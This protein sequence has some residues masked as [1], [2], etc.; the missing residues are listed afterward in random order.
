M[1]L[2]DPELVRRQYASEAGLKVRRESQRRFRTGP[3]AF[4]VAFDVISKL[5]RA[6]CSRSV[7]GWAT[8]PSGSR[9]RR[10]PR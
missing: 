3:D 2:N 1:Q 7:A 4:D 6:A 10:G 8:S 9:G 5:N